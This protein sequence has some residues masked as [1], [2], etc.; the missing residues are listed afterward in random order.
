MQQF[1]WRHAKI[2]VVGK[3]KSEGMGETYNLDRLTVLELEVLF[4]SGSKSILNSL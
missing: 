3:D 4:E 2:N 1:V